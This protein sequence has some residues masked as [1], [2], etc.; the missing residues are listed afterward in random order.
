MPAT[1][2]EL[3]GEDILKEGFT[4]SLLYAFKGYFIIS[5]CETIYLALLL[6]NIIPSSLITFVLNLKYFNHI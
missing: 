6:A 5:L 2:V 4:P 3:R 1:V